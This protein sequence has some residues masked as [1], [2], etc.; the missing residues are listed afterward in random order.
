[1]EFKVSHE[2]ERDIRLERR[3]NPPS[4]TEGFLVEPKVGI[5]PTTCRLRTESRQIR[6]GSYWFVFAV[7]D[8]EFLVFPFGLVRAGLGRK[9]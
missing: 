4:V 5:E 2:L 1:M 7:W 8:V 6:P 9:G 3:V